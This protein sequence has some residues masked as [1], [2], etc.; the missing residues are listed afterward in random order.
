MPRQ[1][2]RLSE[3]KIYHVM[4]H[5][6][7]KLKRE[8]SLSIRQIANLLGINRKRVKGRFLDSY[9]FRVV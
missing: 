3:S 8:S 2:R 1:G 6:I 4:I 9:L 7:S 5:L